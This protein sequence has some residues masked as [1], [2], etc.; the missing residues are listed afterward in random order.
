MAERRALVRIDGQIKETPTGD[1]LYGAGTGG[2]FGTEYQYAITT[3]QTAYTTTTP[4]TVT[5]LTTGSLPSGTYR[6]EWYFEMQMSTTTTQPTV[7]VDYSGTVIGTFVGRTVNTANYFPISGFGDV[8]ISGVHTI[9]IR[10][11]G[12][13]TSSVN[14]KN[15]KISIY[16]IM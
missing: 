3:T 1:T 14:I 15:R 2:S 7:E 12:S 13:N 8:N 5:S 9:T 10:Y 4:T 16:R 6:I 11:T